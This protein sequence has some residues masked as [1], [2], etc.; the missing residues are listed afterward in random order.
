MEYQDILNYCLN[1]FDGAVLI[2]SWG[3]KG[4]F[5]NPKNVL[6]RGVY[7]LT[8]KEKDGNNDK[9]SNLNRENIYRVNIGLRKQTFLN[10]FGYL[11]KRPPAGGIV[12]MD[13]D[14][15][16]LNKI[17]PHPVYAWMGWISILN[18]SRETFESIKPFIKEAYEFAQEKFK[19]RITD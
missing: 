2:N 4:I 8:I 15:T 10:L 13:F 5:Y 18:P 17:M 19:K 3:E 14:F 7:I 9:G 12:D 11:P 1:I 16:E 6:K